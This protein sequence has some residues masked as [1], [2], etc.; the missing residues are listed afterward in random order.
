[1]RLPHHLS[2]TKAADSS[3]TCHSLT[4]EA[5]R[6]WIFPCDTTVPHGPDCPVILGCFSLGRLFGLFQNLLKRNALQFVPFAYP[7]PHVNEI[8]QTDKTSGNR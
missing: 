6:R 7:G 4:H 2:S 5:T 3:A 8:G 1:M